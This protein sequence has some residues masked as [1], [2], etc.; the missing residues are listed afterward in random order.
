MD[1]MT[2]VMFLPSAAAAGVLPWA[3]SPARLRR[4][5]APGSLALGGFGR[6]TGAGVFVNP[7]ATP[8]SQTAAVGGINPPAHPRASVR[9]SP[10]R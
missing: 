5:R 2:T 9:L 7:L 3:N 6:G 1:S 4:V 10:D 8:A